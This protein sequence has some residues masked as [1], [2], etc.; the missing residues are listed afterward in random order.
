MF[1]ALVLL[2]VAL[3]VVLVKYHRF[4]FGA[5]QVPT[6]DETSVE[7]TPNSVT[8][9]PSASAT[10][11]KKHV[12]PKRSTEPAAA[13]AGPTVVATGRTALPPLDAEVVTGDKHHIVHPGSNSVTIGMLPNLGSGVAGSTAMKSAT[14][15]ALA[16]DAAERVRMD[17]GKAQSSPRTVGTSYLPPCPETQ[18]SV[19]LQA[20]IGTDGIVQDMRVLSGPA[21]LVSAAQE[22]VRQWQFKPYLQSGQ[23]VETQAKI[24]VNFTIKVLQ[25]KRT[26]DEVRIV[27]PEIVAD[28]NSVSVL[29]EPAEDAITQTE[30]FESA[31]ERPLRDFI[32][33]NIATLPIANKRLK[34][35]VDQSDRNGVRYPTDVGPIDIL[36]EDETGNFVVFELKLSRG[37][38]KAMG[39]LLRY[40]GWVKKTLAG[41]HEVYGVIVAKDI[42]QKLRFAALP[43]PHVSLLEYEIDFRLR[44]AKLE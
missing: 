20:R 1:F 7:S 10:R 13:V 18:G 23:P 4:W 12:A 33:R 8:Q 2:L 17:P 39:Q 11:T 16:T 30:Q 15:S 38:D 21:M 44:A 34:L 28:A 19:V 6:A 25:K 36:A 27:R 42:D 14:E 40:M 3:T 22:A 37:A 26:D 24:I 9:S 32:A 41:P 31:L 35:F 29:G 5:D 43:V